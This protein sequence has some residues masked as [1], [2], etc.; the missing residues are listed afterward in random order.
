MK[1]I[2]HTP[3]LYLRQFTIE[4]APLILHLNNDPEILKYLHEPI[5]CN[6]ADAKAMLLKN[7]F[8]QYQNNLGRWAAFTKEKNNFIGW[9]GLKYRPELKEFDLGY[10]FT[11]CS[12]GFGYAT[13]AAMH[14]IDY[15]FTNL[16]LNVI[17]GRSH[18]Q[19]LASIKVLEKVGMQYV[20]EAIIDDCPVK[21][22]V[23]RN[24][25]VVY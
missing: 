5:L 15:G 17:T 12:W 1:I 2:F 21:T 20:S 25:K 14:T 9:C 10:R 18:I 8:P 13:E 7:I 16:H 19:N 22:Y 11:K 24:P 3:R 23:I 4:D 6:E